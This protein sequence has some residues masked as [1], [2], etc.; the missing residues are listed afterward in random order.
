MVLYPAKTYSKLKKHY[1]KRYHYL[2]PAERCCTNSSL[3]HSSKTLNC[4]Q[5]IIFSHG[6]ALHSM[7]K[8]ALFLLLMWDVFLVAPKGSGTH[9]CA[10]CSCKVVVWTVLTQSSRTQTGKAKTALLPWVLQWVAVTC[11]KQTSKKSI[12]RPYRWAWN[13]NGLH[14]R[15]I[16]AAQYRVLRERG[17]SL[18]GF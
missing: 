17:H 13:F 1:S 6:F 3:A 8:Q 11:S 7:S 15:W 2:L 18:R 14:A 10:A 5:G 16:F 12:Q 9:H 4:R